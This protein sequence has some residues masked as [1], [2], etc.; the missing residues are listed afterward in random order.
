MA[1]TTPTAAEQINHLIAAHVKS[2]RAALEA[3]VKKIVATDKAEVEKVRATL[4]K[5]P[6]ADEHAT[7]AITPAATDPQLPDLSLIWPTIMGVR[8]GWTTGFAAQLPHS[9]PQLV[10]DL[11]LGLAVIT[12]CTNFINLGYSIYNPWFYPS[13]VLFSDTLGNTAN[14][15]LLPFAPAAMDDATLELWFRRQMPDLTPAELFPTGPTTGNSLVQ[16]IIWGMAN[17]QLLIANNWDVSGLTAST[18]FPVNNATL[19]V[20]GRFLTGR[21]GQNIILRGVDLPLLDNW[22]FPGSD[23]LTELAQ[24]GANCVRI[25]WYLNYNDSG[26][27][28]YT[29][30]NLGNFLDRCVA[31]NIIPILML[32]DETCQSDPNLMNSYFVPFYTN[33]ESYSGS[34]VRDEK[35]QAD[36]TAVLKSRQACLILNL[37]NELGYYKWADDPSSALTT[38][39]AAYSKA[40]SSMRAAGFTC[41]LMIDAPDCG[42]TLDA[43][44]SIGTQLVAADPLHNLMLSTHAYWAGYDGRP[45]LAPAVAANLPIVFAARTTPPPPATPTRPS[46]PRCS[47][48]RLAGSPGAGVQTN[49]PPASSPPT[50][51]SPTS[52][53][54]AR[55]SSTTPPTA[56]KRRQSSICPD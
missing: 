28:A 21:H 52:H 27:P 13:I 8:A 7:P 46:S 34:Q 43:F 35:N 51:P 54:T 5:T 6:T 37:A 31:A 14:V 56:S 33:S 19:T 18:N 24:S 36:F 48:I 32:A 15:P 42:S 50:A 22:S 53:P 2:T 12:I 3:L 29:A 23:Y 44:T 39:A 1:E 49:A 45:Y 55:T 16:Y 26:R 30:D 40:I 9:S 20:S 4:Y 41:P 38:Y 10:S 25:Q 17:R 11:A 47:R